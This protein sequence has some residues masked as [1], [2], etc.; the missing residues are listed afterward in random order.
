MLLE[1]RSLV[2]VKVHGEPVALL[3]SPEKQTVLEPCQTERVPEP[4]ALPSP[5]S[6][7]HRAR[8]APDIARSLARS[9]SALRSLG[10]MQRNARVSGTRDQA[11]SSRV[12]HVA[13]PHINAWNHVQ[14][15]R[16]ALNRIRW[17]YSRCRRAPITDT[18]NASRTG[19]LS[20][21]CLDGDTGSHRGL[22]CL[23][24]LSVCHG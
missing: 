7:S 23:S 10:S 19:H 14:V 22:W 9:T 21:C 13:I 5:Y 15:Q 12:F 17:D 8:A 1:P 2:K 11:N 4:V 6:S 24:C 18:M 20:A 16:F 3:Q